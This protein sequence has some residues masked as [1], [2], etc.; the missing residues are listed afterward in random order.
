MYLSKNLELGVRGEATS[1]HRDERIVS[2]MGINCHPLFFHR[3]LG[4]SVGSSLF[5][6]PLLSDTIPVPFKFYACTSQPFLRAL[7]AD[8]LTEIYHTLA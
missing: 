4:D 2:I 5:L 7:I 3:E 1:P 6:C 8:D